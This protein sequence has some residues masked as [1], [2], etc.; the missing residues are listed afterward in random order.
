MA[1]RPASLPTRPNLKTSVA[2]LALPGAHLVPLP[3]IRPHKIN[4]HGA[5]DATDVAILAVLN[6]PAL[7]AR[8]A[9]RGVAAAE[10]FAAGLLPD[11]VLRLT[12][13]RP[14]GGGGGGPGS[15]VNLG[16][17][18]V[19][20]VT[21]SDRVRAAQAHL[22]AVDLAL[23]W[24][25]WQVAQRAR[26]LAAEIVAERRLRAVETQTRKVVNGW[27]AALHRLQT[28]ADASAVQ[29]AQTEALIDELTDASDTTERKLNDAEQS[30]RALLGLTPTAKL[31]LR[32]APAPQ[33]GTAAIA[34]AIRNLP[35]RRADLLALA[36]GFRSKDESLRAAVAAQFPAITVSFLRES[37]VEGVTSLGIGLT[38]RLPFFNGNRGVIRKT[39]AERAALRASYQAR[40]DRAVSDV[41]RLE[42]DHRILEQEAARLKSQQPFI[43]S[44]ATQMQRLAA[45]GA[46]DR[47]Q[48]LRLAV[49]WYQVK[50]RE[51]STE[52]TLHKTTI[53]LETLLGVPPV[54]LAQSP[55]VSSS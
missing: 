39:E 4:L 55:R 28:A 19:P 11:P 37:D 18:L 40:L 47:M 17:A 8:G 34:D 25:G 35:R 29:L 43:H 26:W 3:A 12:R 54:R 44:Y 32:A 23:L 13:V 53:A 52:L 20:L 38:L 5:L 16:E 48:A 1:Y 2:G 42:G 24:K 14:T 41:S 7:K 22:H 27:Q 9:R 50:R 46:A 30:L 49:Q 10:L 51:I 45:T 6:D 33:I 21:R 15:S 31:R 36:A